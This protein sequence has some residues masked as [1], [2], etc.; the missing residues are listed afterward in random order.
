MTRPRVLVVDDNAV[1]LR[2]MVQ[3]LQDLGAE[4][5][6]VLGGRN[7][8]PMLAAMT[9]APDLILTDLRMPDVGGEEILRR[10]RASETLSSIP[11]VA[12]TGAGTDQ[13]FDLI[14]SK[15]VRERELREALRLARRPS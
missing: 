11:V 15:P 13:S 7:A 5:V 2:I 8:L 10:V 12:V 4:A 14:L 3:R 9:P 1:L 6:P